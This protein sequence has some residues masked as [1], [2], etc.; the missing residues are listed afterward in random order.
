M[1]PP[2]PAKLKGTGKV[3]QK[4]VVVHREVVL[5]QSKHALAEQRVDWATQMYFDEGS[6]Q[7]EGTGLY[8]LWDA[9]GVLKASVGRWYGTE[10]PTNNTAEVKALVEGLTFIH[11]TL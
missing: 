2:P 4:P 7:R 1:E 8:V 5:R 3:I 9:R 11:A 10:A 6:Q